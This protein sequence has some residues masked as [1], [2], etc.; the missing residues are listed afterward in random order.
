MAAR[1]CSKAFG[2]LLAGACGVAA[3]G[4][5]LHTGSVNSPPEVVQISGPTAAD[6]MKGP[7]T[8]RAVVRDPDQP[9]ETLRISWY[10]NKG[11]NGCPN[12]LEAAEKL[13]E[14]LAPE[15]DPT[16]TTVVVQKPEPF[17]VWAVVHDAH[18]AAAFKVLA[19]APTGLKPSSDITV[20]RSKP[21]PWAPGNYELYS[22]FQLAAPKPDPDD[23]ATYHWTVTDPAGKSGDGVA[24]P[25]PNAADV[26]V[27]ADLP[28]RYVVRLEARSPSAQRSNSTLD[29]LVEQDRPPCIRVE[30]ASPRL[31]LPTFSRPLDEPVLFEVTVDDDGDPYPE[32]DGRVSEHE[33]VWYVKGPHDPQFVRQS[34]GSSPQLNTFRLTPRFTFGDE[35]SVRVLYKDRVVDRDFT[36][37]F[38]QN[39]DSCALRMVVPICYQWVTWKIQYK[40]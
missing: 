27:T 4:C 36:A 33:F 24:C 26:C 1:G 21:S 20:V 8:Y 2:P 14:K 35:V 40:E 15:T 38:N 30:S 5:I 23:P 19:V 29:L 32:T 3:L 9:A 11:S 39:P 7:N 18:D 37:C 28:G 22:T 34:S 31:G 25:P 13:G 16:T 12:G 6:I 17:C 10:T